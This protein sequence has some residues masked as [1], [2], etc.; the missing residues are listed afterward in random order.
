MASPLIAV[1]AFEAK[2]RLSELLRETE[3]G[4]SFLIRRRGKAVARL[5]PPA[6]E[7]HTPAPQQALGAFREIRHRIPGTIK[8]R[9]L[10]E[11]GRRS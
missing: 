6:D 7:E 9:A 10:I 8:I 1:S 4:R 3:H 11:E 5:L 2:T